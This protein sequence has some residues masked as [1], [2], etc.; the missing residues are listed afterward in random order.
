M[1]QRKRRGY[2]VEPNDPP[3][4]FMILMKVI[5]LVLLAL[6]IYSINLVIRK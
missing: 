5:G 2:M 6:I 4:W 1:K 3:M